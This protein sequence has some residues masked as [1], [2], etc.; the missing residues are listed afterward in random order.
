MATQVFN[1]P[2]D[3]TSFFKTGANSGIIPNWQTAVAD[4]WPNSHEGDTGN[5]VNTE[6]P[7]SGLGA[8]LAVFGIP[9]DT[10]TIPADATLNTFRMQFDWAISNVPDFVTDATSRLD[11]SVSTGVTQDQA[12]GLSSG[13]YD[14]TNTA[15]N[16]IGSTVVADLYNNFFGWIYTFIRTTGGFGTIT[17]RV[18]I[19]NFVLTVDYTPVGP[20]SPPVVNAGEDSNC[21][22]STGFDLSGEIIGSALTQQWT[23]ATGPGD[24]T[25]TDDEDLTTHVDFSE[26]GVYLLKLS[27]T[28]ADGPNH[29]YIKLVVLNLDALPGLNPDLE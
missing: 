12:E 29:S 26:N 2:A 19:S 16:V 22:L 23:K 8:D 14:V 1:S 15:I 10:L 20:V 3:F 28:S 13:S 24:V 7:A 27:I 11:S 21:L 18:A 25:F 17:R 9:V 6:E 5:V 4:L